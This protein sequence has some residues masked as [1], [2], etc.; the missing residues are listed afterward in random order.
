MDEWADLT[1]VPIE[2]LLPVH[3]SD[4]GRHRA[5]GTEL[6]PNDGSGDKRTSGLRQ[7][8]PELD[9]SRLTR[10]PSRHAFGFHDVRNLGAR[11]GLTIVR[12]LRRGYV[13]I[14][15]RNGAWLKSPQHVH[16]SQKHAYRFLRTLPDTSALSP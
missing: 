12:S 6:R 5:V 1:H 7:A 15:C 11:K 2:H 9:S 4:H 13:R 14:E 8:A 10:N 3:H 16:F